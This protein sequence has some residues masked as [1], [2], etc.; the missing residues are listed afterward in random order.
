MI[1][2]KK[3]KIV[4]ITQNEDLYKKPSTMP[5]YNKTIEASFTKDAY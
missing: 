2:K 3:G 1:K 5:G 4:L